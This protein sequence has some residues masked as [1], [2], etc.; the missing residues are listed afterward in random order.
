MLK[1]FLKGM[2]VSHLQEMQ[3]FGQCKLFFRGEPKEKSL[4][5]R[6]RDDVTP[7]KKE[8]LLNDQLIN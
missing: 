6:G 5:V 2:V 8:E 1:Q 7:L 3:S 4:R